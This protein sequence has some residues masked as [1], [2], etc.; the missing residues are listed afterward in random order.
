MLSGPHADIADAWITKS[1]AEIHEIA[2]EDGSIAVVPVGSVEQHGHHLPVGTDSLLVS[3]VVGEASDRVDVPLL[4]TP[5]VWSGYSPHHLPFGG[6][7]SLEF[8]HLLAVLED[9]ADTALENGFD[10]ILFVNGHGGNKALLSSAV[11]TIG[12]DHPDSEVLG[13]TYFDLAASFID[14]IRDSDPGGMAHGGEFETAL[15]LHLYPDLVKEDRMEGTPLDEPYDQGLVDLVEFGPLS[16]Y[17]PFDEYSES[18]AIGEPELGSAEKGAEIFD[19][20]GDELAALFRD[21]YERNR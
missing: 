21:V 11:S 20:L 1:Y 9:V 12:T 17:R 6:T 14:E 16:V 2:A 15:M 5:P 19:R 7:I 4:R 3:A 10:A 18:G 13:I 8:E